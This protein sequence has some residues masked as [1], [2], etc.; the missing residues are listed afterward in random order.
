MIKNVYLLCLYSL[1]KRERDRLIQY[2]VKQM[3]IDEK[4]FDDK[5][6]KEEDSKEYV[7]KNSNCLL[8]Y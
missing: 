5:I 2:G 1:K 4:D 3:K 8:M 6:F 7:S